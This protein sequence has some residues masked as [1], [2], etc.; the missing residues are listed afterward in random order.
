MRCRSGWKAYRKLT[1]AEAYLP[2][3]TA[4]FPR[5]SPSPTKP[6]HTATAL[7]GGCVLIRLHRPLG[8]AAPPAPISDLA[9]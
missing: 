2:P 5:P 9:A 7:P 4:P 1:A 6:N 3:D 8:R